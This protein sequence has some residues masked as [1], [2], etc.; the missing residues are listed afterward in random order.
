[1]ANQGSRDYPTYPESTN[2]GAKDTESTGT[3][4]KEKASEA[5]GKAK[6]KAA[7]LGRS[8]TAKIDE[9]REPAAG[10]L[11]SAAAKLHEG[12][13]SLPGGE[14]VSDET[15]DPAV[16]NEAGLD[17]VPALAEEAPRLQ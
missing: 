11:D 3:S 14:T 9:Q 13:E 10:A 6:E 16:A 8:A 15:R 5:A 17:A 4:L 1:M 7:D 2:P 12:A